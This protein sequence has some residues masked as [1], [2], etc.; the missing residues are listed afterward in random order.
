MLVDPTDGLGI[1]LEFGIDPITVVARGAAIFAGTQRIS[2][3]ARVMP[4]VKPTGAFS[5]SFPDWQFVGN[6]PELV[7]FGNVQAADGRDMSAYSVEMAN[8]SMIPPYRT[9]R[10]PLQANGGFMVTLR[11]QEGDQNVFS[12]EVADSTGIPQEIITDPENLT[13]KIGLVITN[14]PLTHSVGVALANNEVSTYFEK[15]FCLL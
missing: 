6:D 8:E 7:I 11:A 2:E 12:V 14:P 1:P 15:F 3:E 10:V 9:G 13:Y 4:A 5:V